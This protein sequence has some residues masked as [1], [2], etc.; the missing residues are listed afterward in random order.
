[1]GT[2]R[3]EHQRRDRAMSELA[4][5][6][7]KAQ[8]DIKTLTK[9]PSNDDLAFVYAHYK[10]A[11]EGDVSGSRPGRLNMVARAKYDAW[12]NVSGLSKDEAMRRY[13]D[14]VGELLETHR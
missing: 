3:S 6:F 2:A 14:K 7:E 5:E 12:S 8:A 9:R 1:M 10:Q 13:V 11:T 4:A